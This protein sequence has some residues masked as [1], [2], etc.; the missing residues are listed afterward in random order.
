MF[1]LYDSKYTCI[2]FYVFMC[3]IFL[4]IFFQ[5]FFSVNF[6]FFLKKRWK[7]ESLKRVILNNDCFGE[8]LSCLIDIVPAMLCGHMAANM[9]A[10]LLPGL[11]HY[12][13]DYTTIYSL[14]YTTI[15]S[16]DSQLQLSPAFRTARQGQE[17]EQGQQKE[18]GQGAK[19]V[20]KQ[21]EQAT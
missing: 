8:P 9:A 11:Q 6:F 19:K 14:D 10:T 15:G 21:F 17:K 7:V 20:E 18:Q 1:V 16:Q 13:K 5:E 2:P 3:N 12:S 4:L